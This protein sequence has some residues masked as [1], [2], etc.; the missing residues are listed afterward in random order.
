M[1]CQKPGLLGRSMLPFEG[2]PTTQNIT[3]ENEIHFRLPFPEV[4]H[5]VPY[6]GSLSVLSNMPFEGLFNSLVTC[7]WNILYSPPMAR[8]FHMKLSIRQSFSSFLVSVRSRMARRNVYWVSFLEWFSFSHFT[9]VAFF[10]A[11][12]IQKLWIPFPGVCPIPQTIQIWEL[13]IL[14]ASLCAQNHAF[15]KA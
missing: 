12:I 3:K 4:N 5:T 14:T 7:S 10:V 1:P 15:L 9:A 6:S 8:H 2:F 13:W 11:R